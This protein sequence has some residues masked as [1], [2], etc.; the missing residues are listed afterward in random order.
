MTTNKSIVNP[1]DLGEIVR[2]ARKDAGLTQRDAAMLCG[3]SPPFMNA[4][5]QGKPTIQ[6]GKALEV[7][8]KLGI[9]IEAATMDMNS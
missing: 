6:L 8:R 3:V 4:L 9:L 5:E 1:Q 2:L 7:C